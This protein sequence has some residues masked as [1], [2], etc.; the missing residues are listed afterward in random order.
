[1]TR[2][3]GVQR[4]ALFAVA[5]GAAAP[6]MARADDSRV[7]NLE[8]RA[9]FWEEQG[10]LDKA[11]EAWELV[12]KVE[13]RNSR[14]L[15][16]L[17]RF[18]SQLGHA[19]RARYYEEQL[20]LVSPES[21]VGRQAPRPLGL[22]W[23]TLL[24][25]ARHL[26]A[27]GKYREAV[28][29][30]R[31]LFGERPT[32]DRLALEYYQTLAGMPEG[33]AEARKGFDQLLLRNPNWL[34][35]QMAYAELLTYEEAWRRDGIGRLEVL[36]R[37]AAVTEQARRDWRQALLWLNAR[38]ADK[39][40]Y[41]RYLA[42]APGDTEVAAK[43][44]AIR[45]ENPEAAALRG[46]FSLLNNHELEESAQ[47]FLR[48][49]ARRPHDVDALA[50]LSSVRLAQRRFIEARG[51]ARSAKKFGPERPSVWQ[52]AL[53]QAEFW[54][55]VQ[56]AQDARAALDYARAETLFRAAFVLSPDDAPVAQLMLAEAF[57]AEGRD[58]EAE[59][60]FRDILKVEKLA[61]SLSMEA[62]RGL[63]GVLMRES[64]L[65]E[66][67]TIERALLERSGLSESERRGVRTQLLRARARAEAEHGRNQRAVELLEEALVLAPNSDAVAIELVELHLAL[68][69]PVAAGRVADALLARSP[70]SAEAVIAAAQVDTAAERWG[71][72]LK[73]LERLQTANLTAAARAL[74]AHAVIEVR[75]REA[76]ELQRS[77]SEDEASPRF[78][79]IERIAGDE[80]ELRS[81]A[82]VCLSEAGLKERATALALA[83]LAERP[84]RGARFRCASVLLAAGEA[85]EE[86]L[87]R[88]IA[89][90]DADAN[91]PP[92]ERENLASLRRAMILKEV[93]R[94]RIAGDYAR[95]FRA[96]EPL[97]RL[98]PDD[99]DVLGALGR[100]Y[101]GAGEPR[102]AA[103][104]YQRLL[105]GHPDDF[106]LLEATATALLSAG[107]LPAA[108]SIAERTVKKFPA[109]PRAWLLI[110][111]ID[112][113]LGDDRRAREELQRGLDLAPA[114]TASTVAGGERRGALTGDQRALLDEAK[115]LFGDGEQK[116]GELEAL[117]PR[118]GLQAELEKVEQQYASTLDAHLAFRY[119][120]G[121]VGLG[122]VFELSAPLT[123]SLSPG[124]TGRLTAR[125]TPI[126]LSA[127]QTD[128]S[129][130]GTAESFGQNGAFV[131]PTQPL[132]VSSDSGGVA[133]ALRYDIK[134]FGI[135]LGSTPLGFPVMDVV[136]EIGYAGKVGGLSLGIHAFRTAVTDSVLSYAG[137]RDNRTH[138]VWGG[139]RRN[140]GQLDLAYD[141][142]A[143][144]LGLFGSFAYFDGRNVAD[145]LG[146]QYGA[147]VAWKLY[148]RPSSQVTAGLGV[149]VMDYNKDLRYFSFGQGG[150]FSPQMFVAAG[151]PVVWHRQSD[152]L[153]THLEAEVGVD[154]FRENASPFFPN[155]PGLQASRNS[156]PA[157]AQTI[158]G[159]SYPGGDHLGPYGRLYGSIDYQ[160]NRSFL[161]NAS[162]S[163]VF[164]IQFSEVI[165]GLGGRTD[166]VR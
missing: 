96:L 148:R 123:A 155:D 62:E 1:M 146:G 32:N 132:L 67:A 129:G 94:A 119:R 135:E 112:H 47:R 131:P 9:N 63:F 82:A 133:L 20:R 103:P 64:K 88:L 14:A 86:R 19:E 164:A 109:E 54:C 41:D 149:F 80:T 101:V 60:M 139:V 87:H 158:I 34:P 121:D 75:C 125:V 69:N 16:A 102:R 7:V 83:V 28:A 90:L 71:A 6:S 136:G 43:L 143:W 24:A 76:L 49:L 26:A 74:K 22:A 72:A 44:A 21:V 30:Y 159:A 105:A 13:P 29:R 104:V 12:L 65:E 110:G 111:R 46:A 51:L 38:M 50:G 108:R 33:R 52:K 141:A 81:V 17:A 84:S 79:E 39:P 37:T 99:R 163:V 162:C 154:W 127:G 25:E 95:A 151:L 4:I 89:E 122:R 157:D 5:L 40:L 70:D 53:R 45:P 98:A 118:R 117:S 145:N 147:S 15:S 31:Q 10:R 161:F 59:R 152:R 61:A 57:V 8:K 48:L 58:A 120:T 11:I 130:P 107:E 66:A 128:L 156:V 100:L 115:A 3:G 160:V 27:Q 113:A 68:R 36:S 126:Y 165:C 77:S 140:G 150:Y 114:I 78:R 55:V 134:G 2:V 124:R 144:R 42:M 92:R 166:F 153:T 18:H 35:C 73:K 91:L 93:D 142:E 56:E 138:T 106:E 116:P 137:R 23:D 97:Y 85:G